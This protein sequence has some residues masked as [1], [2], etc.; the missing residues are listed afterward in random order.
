MS[1]ANT[2]NAALVAKL[3]NDN[4]IR[5]PRPTS[6]FYTMVDINASGMSDI[7]FVTR[8]LIKKLDAVVPGSAIV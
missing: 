7:D 8:I 3:F 2:T 1:N 5:F 4:N 6:A